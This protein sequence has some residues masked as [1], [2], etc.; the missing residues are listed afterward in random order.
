[1]GL[2]N[3]FFENQLW[4]RY[5]VC[6]RVS[7]AEVILQEKGNEV[8]WRGNKE[9]KKRNATSLTRE[10]MKASRRVTRQR[11][12]NNTRKK[13]PSKTKK[14]MKQRNKERWNEVTRKQGNRDKKQRGKRWKRNEATRNNENPCVS[15]LAHWQAQIGAG[16]PNLEKLDFRGIGPCKP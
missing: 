4:S 14:P 3:S 8:R 11:G 15:F 7:F 9:T 12:N 10:T 2:E 13:R 16:H 5:V 6:H 1:M